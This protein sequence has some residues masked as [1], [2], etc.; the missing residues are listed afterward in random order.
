MTAVSC[1]RR[2]EEIQRAQEE[3]GAGVAEVAVEARRAFA[4]VQQANTDMAKKLLQVAALGQVSSVQ[5]KAPVCI[6]TPSFIHWAALPPGLGDALMEPLASLTPQQALPAQAGALAQDLAA[7]EQAAE[8]QESSALQA[9]EASHAL[10][11]RLRQELQ[12]TRGFEQVIAAGL[13]VVSL[14]NK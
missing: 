8:V 6:P 9:I 13:H 11:A 2:Y 3:L 12:R 1:P 5:A 7:L 4:A 14:Q 10:G